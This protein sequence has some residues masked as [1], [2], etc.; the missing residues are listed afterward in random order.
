M[1]KIFLAED[2]FVVR[3]GIK[4]N[5]DWSAHGYEFVGEA[6][7]GELALPMIRKQKP[8]IVI[9][10]IK[11]PFMDGLELSRL[12]KKEFPWM[13]IVILSGYAEFDYARE[14][15]HIGVAHYLSKPIS[16]DALVAEI[17][18]IA[19]KVEQSKQERQLREKYAKEMS[20]N[21]L[22]EKTE[23]FTK[24]VEGNLSA[25]EI[26]E[27]AD[28]LSMDVSATAYNIFLFKAVSTHH[29]EDEYSGSVVQIYKKLQEIF[30]EAGALVFDHT[31][32]GKAILFKA[33]SPENLEGI[34]KNS[35]DKLLSVMKEYDYVNYYGG[36]GVCVSRLTQVHE[37]YERA[38]HA[39]AHRYMTDESRIYEYAEIADMTAS[40]PQ[41]DFNLSS[42][43]PS[44]L[45]RNRIQEFLRKGS[46]QEAVYF[47]DEFFARLGE[48]AMHSTMFRQYI[49]TDVYFAVAAFL[50][51][52][53]LERDVIRPFDL[54][55]GEVSD[56]DK[57]RSYILELIKSGVKTRDHQASNRYADMIGEVRSYIE[58]HYADEDISLNTLA[59]RVNFSPNHLSMIFSAQTGE[60]FI[61]YL[62]DYRMEKAKELLRCTSKRSV[63]ISVEV[64][65]KDPHYFS[66]LFKKTQGMTPTQ[67]RNN[68]H[69]GEEE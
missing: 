15:I 64:G 40:F 60:T 14:A 2:E 9:T 13:E 37:A 42:V 31:I 44:Y 35:I 59:S 17:D 29:E 23:L 50:E 52:H 6:S 46:E 18:K 19:E 28:K 33:D 12:I 38:S 39:Y 49:A 25:G 16:G 24:I 4:N 43:N 26:L 65:Y 48:N 1:L 53:G 61:K 32:E 3:E 67:Y 54:A 66:Y 55:S 11:M 69:S 8:D 45:D 68:G 34:I 27:Q 30:E 56:P 41:E 63:D 47:V 62:T 5:I 36:I 57:T 51:E 22:R 21:V 10:D 20:E 58:E 7:D